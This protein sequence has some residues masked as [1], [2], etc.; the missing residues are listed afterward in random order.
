MLSEKTAVA[1]KGKWRGILMALGLPESCLKDRH[2]PCPLCGGVDRFRWDNKEGKGTYICGQCGA[3]DGFKLAREFTGRTFVEVASEIDRIV[4][5]IKFEAPRPA[6]SPEDARRFMIEVYKQTVPVVAGDLVHKYLASRGVEELIYPPSMRFGA[7]LRDGEGGVRPC[8]VAMVG[9][10]GD[11][12][13]RGRQKFVSM[14]R[15]F[16]RSDGSAKADMA[17]PRKMMP[18]E[19]PE[20]ACVML[21]EWTGSGPIGIAEG[22]ETAMSASAL[23]GI[24]VWAGISTSIMVKWHPPP[25]ADEVVI[26]GDNDPKYGGQG[27]AYTL[28]HRLAVKNKD[29]PVTVKI[30]DVPGSDWNDVLRKEQAKNY[31]IRDQVSA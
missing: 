28:A 23:F 16:L 13:D 29:M 1:A 22:I 3:G 7:A 26:F 15:T 27:A 10:H 5:N 12:D 24:P 18:G 20:G 11:L 21:S 30:P 8:M 25:G 19:L 4:G 9:I 14:H 6:T 17:G 2:G 31:R